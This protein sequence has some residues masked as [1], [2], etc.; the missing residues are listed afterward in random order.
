[1]KFIYI[2]NKYTEQ[3]NKY[4]YVPQINSY[5]GLIKKKIIQF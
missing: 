1:M 2:L 4:F 3:T 5:I